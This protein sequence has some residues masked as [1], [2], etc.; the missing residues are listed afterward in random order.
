VRE[1]LREALQ[2]D[3]RVFLMGEDVGRY[4]GAYA[5]SMGL[6]ADFGEERIRDTPLSESGFVGAG[7]GAAL[8]GMRP[9]VEIMTVN[10]SLLALDQIVNNAATLRHMSGGQLSV[11]LV[12]RMATG[13]GRQLAA[14]HSHSLECW[15]AHV[16]GIKVVAPATVADARGM[17]WTALC[18]PDPVV[19]FEHAGL[20]NDEGDVETREDLSVDIARAAIRRE[21]KDVTLVTYGGSLKKS[22]AAAEAMTREGI[23]C[24]VIDLRSLRPL[25]DR[26]I[27]ASV[28]KTH[29][30]VII[31]EGWRSGSLAAEISTRIMEQA[32]FELDAPVGR[33]CSAEVPIPYPK[34]LETAA[35]PQAEGIIAAVRGVLRR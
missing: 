26:T 31:D 10:F 14:Q 9:I 15:Y 8:G 30:A 33:V 1:A 22:L 24:E 20:Y 29:R 12:I 25:D 18:D 13:A 27:M 11:P 2:R 19:I 17:L 4:G 6:L 35:T 28:A 5:C 21:G 23:D 3:E 16:P 7:I 32:F 34:H